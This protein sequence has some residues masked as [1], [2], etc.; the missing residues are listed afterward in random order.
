MSIESH[1]VVH[2]QYTSA[3]AM[4]KILLRLLSS[5]HKVVPYSCNK[6]MTYYICIQVPYMYHPFSSVHTYIRKT[7]QY[8][9]LT[10]TFYMPLE[11]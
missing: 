6:N 9:W 2:E 5:P 10:E 3:Y 11:P 8:P 7:L 4:Q 1:T